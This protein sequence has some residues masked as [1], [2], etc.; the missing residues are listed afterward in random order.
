MTTYKTERLIYRDVSKADIP[1]IQVYASDKEL[2]KKR[3]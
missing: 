3:R 2:S 1:F